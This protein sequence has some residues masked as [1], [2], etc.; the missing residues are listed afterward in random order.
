MAFNHRKTITFRLA[1]TARAARGRSGSHLTRIGLHPGQDSVLKTLSEQDGL[2]MSQLAQSLAVQ[3]PT[4]TKMVSRLA[5]QGYVERRASKGDGRQAHVYLTQQGR[6]AIL[7]IDKGWKRLEK[8]ALAGLDDKDVKR[9]RK[10]L[11]Q[12][13]RNLS[14]IPEDSEDDIADEPEAEAEATTE[15]LSNGA[16]DAV[17]S[18]EP[19]A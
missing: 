6:D 9:L 3:P 7:D 14:A 16:T 4:V 15:G 18:H 5:A 12:I 8:E 13:E 17:E 1:Q 19:V 10:L 11:R 2:S